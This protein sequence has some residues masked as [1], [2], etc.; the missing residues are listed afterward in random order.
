[1]SF[2]LGIMSH[3]FVGYTPKKVGHPGSRYCHVIA[4]AHLDC[5]YV[6]FRDRLCGY[7]QF[8]GYKL[9][10]LFLFGY[11]GFG[12]FGFKIPMMEKHMEE[13]KLKWEI[14][15]YSVYFRFVASSQ[16][17]RTATLGINYAPSV[18]AVPAIGPKV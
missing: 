10:T 1:M 7:R 6:C 16:K 12:G 9:Y 3:K 5:H 2:L 15:M 17:L 4:E 11:V 14:G 18:Y 8:L 13:S